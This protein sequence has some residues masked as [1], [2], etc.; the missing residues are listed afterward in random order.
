[1]PDG[2]VISFGYDANG[3]LTSITPPGH[4][5]HGFAYSAIDLPSS[6]TAP[7]VSGGNQTTYS[8]NLDQQLTTI[9]RPDNQTISFAYDSGARLS[10]VTIPAAFITSPITRRRASWRASPRRAGGTLSYTYDG[11]LLT[12]TAWA[13]TVAGNVSRVFDNNFRVTSQSVNGANA[14]NFTYDNDGLLTGAGNLSLTRH[15]QNGFVI[16]TT[17]GGVTDSRSYTG[18]GEASAYNASYNSSGLYSTSYTY[19]K[20]SRI[21]QK[22]ETVV[23][24]TDT[25]DYTYDLAG[26]LTQVKTNNVVTATYTYDSNSNR[27]SYAGAGPAINGTY[28]N[29]DRLTQYGST[30]YAYTAN[31]ELQTKTV[32]GQTTQYSYDVLGNLKAVAL[33][34][35]TQ[36]DY[37]VDG[38]D[39]RIG[40][41]VNG[42]LA[43][44]FLYQNALNPV[45]EL[46]GSNNVVTHF[47]YG[48]RSN[49]PDYM[50]RGGVTY[51]IIS[52][53]LGSPRLVVNIT[54]GAIA[55]RMDYDE[56][57]RVI[58]DTNPGFQPFGFAGGLYDKDTGMAR[59]GAR[60]YDAETGRWTTKDPLLF[61]GLDSN[62]YVYVHNDPVNLVDLNG[63]NPLEPFEPFEGVHLLHGTCEQLEKQLRRAQRLEELAEIRKKG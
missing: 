15:T 48:S 32:G 22:V 19:D 29:Q 26:R 14:I 27:L 35:G 17:L 11:A 44:G 46:D 40:K 63:Q 6:Y 7:D 39:R 20:L 52:D 47:V 59:F 51:R 56:F 43:Q 37:L 41:K 1:L 8:Y 49:V 34:N 21:T 3:N 50:I 38:Q 62:L 5:A 57:G 12:Q 58:A 23:G 10:T 36:I 31:G 24:V 61:A 55:Q 30:T 28:D 45:A 4:P 25:Y 53:H 13:G 16:S 33:P 60:D 54:T 9:T 18:F 42:T 2:R